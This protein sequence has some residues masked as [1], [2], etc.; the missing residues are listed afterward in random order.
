MYRRRHLCNRP[1]GE[2]TVVA[3]MPDD[4][5]LPRAVPEWIARRRSSTA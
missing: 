2:N 5:F 4:M 3:H 1:L